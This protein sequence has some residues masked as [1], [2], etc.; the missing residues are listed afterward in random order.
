MKSRIIRARH[1]I[2]MERFKDAAS[3]AR[4]M[5][6]DFE[7]VAVSGALWRAGAVE[8]ALTVVRHPAVSNADDWIEAHTAAA[9]ARGGDFARAEQI[10]RDNLQPE[11]KDFVMSEVVKNMAEK[12][13]LAE[14][15]ALVVQINDPY[16]KA[17]GLAAVAHAYAKSGH[18]GDLQRVRVL[19]DNFAQQIDDPSWKSEVFS[20]LAESAF[21]QEKKGLAAAYISRAADAAV[22]IHDP[23]P[24]SEAVNGLLKL[25]IKNGMLREARQMADMQTED[26]R[27][28]DSYAEVLSLWKTYSADLKLPQFV[29]F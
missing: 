15:E 24:R 17:I 10:A 19:A 5:V 3:L 21:V 2:E 22:F 14:A 16:R 25:S 28:V 11:F 9:I 27:K 8:E 6:D 29:L 26:S 18:I 20:T 13:K 7:R 12:G 23:L 1:Y 4:G